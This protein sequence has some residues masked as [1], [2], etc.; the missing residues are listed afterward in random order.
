MS[1]LL[2]GEKLTS[3]DYLGVGKEISRSLPANPPDQ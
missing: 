3:E 2:I 1:V